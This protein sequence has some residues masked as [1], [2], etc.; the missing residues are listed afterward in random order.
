MTR[1]QFFTSRPRSERLVSEAAPHP[2]RLDR[3]E[4]VVH[5]DDLRALLD[6][7]ERKRDASPQPFVCRRFARERTDGPLA[8]S[9]H[10][11][12]AA[13]RVEK[14]EPVHQLEVVADILAEAEARID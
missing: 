1:K 12:G 14:R 9:A 8:A 2:K 4:D 10:D 13:E 3:L 6:G 7:L 11:Q 5:A